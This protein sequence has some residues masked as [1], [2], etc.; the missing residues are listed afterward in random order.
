MS[1]DG[2]RTEKC[3]KYQVTAL[4][5]TA[6]GLRGSHVRCMQLA[7]CSGSLLTFFLFFAVSFKAVF[8]CRRRSNTA[9]TAS[10]RIHDQ[11]LEHLEG[12]ARRGSDP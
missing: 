3:K 10:L 7:F 12:L 4:S 8:F 11:D 1:K 5:T 2:V 9:R 6:W